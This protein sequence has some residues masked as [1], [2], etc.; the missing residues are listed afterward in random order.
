[1]NCEEGALRASNKEALAEDVPSQ[2]QLLGS[3]DISDFGLSTT[4]S[5]D[6]AVMLVE[7]LL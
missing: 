2:W 5:W 3:R 6:T 1:M 4:F 7:M